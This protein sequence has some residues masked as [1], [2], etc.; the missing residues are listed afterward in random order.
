MASDSE[1]PSN[2]YHVCVEISCWKA[3]LYLRNE[4]DRTKRSYRLGLRVTGGFDDES[5]MYKY[6]YIYGSER[7]IKAFMEYLCANPPSEG[8]IVFHV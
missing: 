7:K 5:R 3:Y 4:I 8:H 6:M 1:D 2:K